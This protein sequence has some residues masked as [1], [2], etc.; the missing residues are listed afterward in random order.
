[1]G[2]GRNGYETGNKQLPGGFS[3]QLTLNW[4]ALG[5]NSGGGEEQEASWAEEAAGL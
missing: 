3:G 1:M 4:G 5:A 2:K